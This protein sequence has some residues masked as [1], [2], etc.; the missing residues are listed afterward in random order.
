M[1]ISQGVIE[2]YRKKINISAGSGAGT[3]YQIKVRVGQSAGS[4]DF[5]VQLDGKCQADFDDIRFTAD[6]GTTLLGH[7]LESVSGAAPNITATF[8]VKVKANLN[9][10]QSIFIYYGNSKAASA[11]SGK[12]TFDLY[13]D[14]ET[15]FTSSG[16]ALDNADTYQI[17]PTYDGSGQTV[18]PDVVYMHDGWNG[19]KYWMAMTPYA[20]SNDQLENPSI[21]VS[22]DGSSWSVPEGL[23][24]PLIGAP[25]CDHNC[26]ADIIYNTN[27]GEMWVYYLDTRR[28]SR[29]GGYEDQ[30]YYNHNFLKL[31]RSSDGINWTGPTTLIDWDFS[32]DRFYL[33]PAVVQVDPTHFYMWMTDTSLNLY[34]FESSDGISWGEPQAINFSEKAWHL[35]VGYIPSKNEFWMITLDNSSGGN[36]AWAVSF[37]GLNWSNFPNRRVMTPGTNTWDSKLYRSCFLYNEEADLL[38]IWYSAYSNSTVWHTGFVS[39]DYS[40]LLQILESDDIADWTIYNNGGS[41]SSLSEN[42]KRGSMSGKLV[43]TSTSSHQ[44][45]L[46]NIP[47]AT[48]FI[49]EWDMYDDMDSSSFKLVRINNAQPGKQTGIGVWT[50]SSSGY[51]AFHNTSYSYTATSVARSE[52]WHKFGLRLSTDS[53]VDYFIDGANVGSLSGLFN[54]CLSISVEGYSGGP[55]A[56]YVDDMRF[57]KAADLEPVV[58]SYSGQEQG[59]WD[60]F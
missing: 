26:D 1:W 4:S 36:I 39:T 25:P 5:D 54:D 44:I 51:Y 23:N 15:S 2:T 17:T 53:S 18:H 40:D 20:N 60:I 6:D 41:W 35:N 57:R 14:F 16:G 58:S 8:W 30:P 27:T 37:D 21:L 55:T 45:V 52:G 7:W 3:E 59:P 43:Q 38:E 49:A 47:V 10:A 46:K 33:S 24:N 19:Y 42:V 12:D 11:S 56:F 9:S 31:F 22:N 34:M 50:G 29:C 32:T 48:D 13:D 28:A